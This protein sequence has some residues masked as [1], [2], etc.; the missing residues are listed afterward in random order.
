M[1]HYLCQQRL[2]MLENCEEL[3][4]TAFRV[5]AMRIVDALF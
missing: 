2:K 3:S 1:K 5:E 4:D